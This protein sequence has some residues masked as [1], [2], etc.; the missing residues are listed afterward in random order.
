VPYQRVDPD[1]QLR[2]TFHTKSIWHKIWNKSSRF[3]SP[4]IPVPFPTVV[5][6]SSTNRD[7]PQRPCMEVQKQL[8]HFITYSDAP[9]I[10][11]IDGCEDGAWGFSLSFCWCLSLP[12]RLPY[13]SPPKYLLLPKTV[14]WLSLPLFMWIQKLGYWSAELG[15]TLVR[16]SVT[17]P[18]VP[19]EGRF[20]I[21]LAVFSVQNS[22]KLQFLTKSLSLPVMHLLISVNWTLK[23]RILYA[24]FYNVYKINV[25]WRYRVSLHIS[26]AKLLNRYEYVWRRFFSQTSS[27]SVNM[28]HIT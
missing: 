18:G 7:I 9:K 28:V 3:A 11:L 19:T 12:T 23:H 8:L 17:F 13:V 24:F 5:P 16:R 4:P 27:G 1:W 25:P 2:Q 6:H 14:T 22:P 20:K 21:L 26:Y 10:I 15:S